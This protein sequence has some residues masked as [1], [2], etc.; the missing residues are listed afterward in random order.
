MTT[1]QLSYIAAYINRALRW[2]FSWYWQTTADRI[3]R[4]MIPDA[5]DDVDFDVKRVLPE[6]QVQRPLRVRLNLK[7]VTLGSI[8]DLKPGD[9]HTASELDP[10]DVPLVSCGEIDNG[11]IGLFALHKVYSPS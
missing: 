2:R 10:G 11:I 5:P 7:E 4:L 1:A 8:Y 3:K 6:P 9:Y